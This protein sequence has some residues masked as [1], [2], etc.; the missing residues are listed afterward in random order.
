MY[1]T[2]N[3]GK[4]QQGDLSLEDL[5]PARPLKSKVFVV[6]LSGDRKGQVFQVTKVTKADET[7]FLATGA[8]A[9]KELAANVCVIEDHLETGCSCSRFPKS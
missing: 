5:K 1:W 3:K 7:V 8:K 4:W 6:A 9:E 2:D